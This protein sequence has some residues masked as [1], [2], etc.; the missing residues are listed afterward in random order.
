MVKN[1]M[2]GY[3]S[4]YDM[5]ATSWFTDPAVWSTYTDSNTNNKA[6]FAIASPTIELYIKSYNAVAA[7]NNS[8][9][10]VSY[11]TVG[12]CGYATLP[13]GLTTSVNGIYNKG[14]GIDWWLAS[15]GNDHYYSCLYVHGNGNDVLNSSVG[16]AN[17]VRPL[18]CIP[19]SEIGAAS[20]TS[21]TYHMEN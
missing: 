4:Y 5:K 17:A 3:S 7:I 9:N 21:C 16:F 18:V 14:S 2:G 8:V 20:D 6:T 15:P 12:T 1:Q 13:S 10:A 19:T 11:P